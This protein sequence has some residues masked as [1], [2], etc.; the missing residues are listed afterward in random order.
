MAGGGLGPGSQGF[1][2]GQRGL[3]Y[4]DLGEI[5]RL[6]PDRF[7]ARGGLIRLALGGI[8]RRVPHLVP[9]ERPVRRVGQGVH[10]VERDRRC[11]A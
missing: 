5:G 1:R 8:S 4:V 3:G 2:I 6:G 10:L 9:G 7:L 11:A